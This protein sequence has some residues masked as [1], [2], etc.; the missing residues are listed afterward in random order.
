MTSKPKKNIC[1]QCPALCCHYITIE[2]DK[3]ATKQ[4]HDDIRW[5][6]YHKGISLL[7]EED[8]WLIQCETTCEHLQ[9][10]HLCGIYEHRPNT[11]RKYSTKNCDYHTIYEGWETQY[12]E[13]ETVEEFDAYLLEEKAKK[14][15]PASA[16]NKKSV[17]KK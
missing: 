16:K 4:D 17:K 11:C 9:R 5:Y 12:K 7:I 15:K 10:D 6:L 3:P 1:L 14:R 8:R 2:I 13:I